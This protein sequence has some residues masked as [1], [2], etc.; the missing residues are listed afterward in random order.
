MSKVRYLHIGDTEA[1]QAAHLYHTA[2]T[3]L[4]QPEESH[5]TIPGPIVEAAKGLQ[6]ACAIWLKSLL[7]QE[8][9]TDV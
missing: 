5:T 7:E 6:K 4:P 2:V 8:I 3:F 1:Q 9:M